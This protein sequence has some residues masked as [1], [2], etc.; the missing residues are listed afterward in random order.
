MLLDS[1]FQPGE[2]GEN[3]T[4]T[5]QAIFIVKFIFGCNNFTFCF[6]YLAGLK[7]IILYHKGCNVATNMIQ[8]K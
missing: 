8:F 6:F 3:Q 4:T 1:S 5:V 7:G 2:N